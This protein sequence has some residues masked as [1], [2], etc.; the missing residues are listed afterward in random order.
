MC[1]IHYFVKLQDGVSTFDL[2]E[3]YD[4][5]LKDLGITQEDL[6]S[7]SSLGYMPMTLHAVDVLSMHKELVKSHHTEP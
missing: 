5:L 1:S 7:L 4:R 3:R 2:I 6:Q